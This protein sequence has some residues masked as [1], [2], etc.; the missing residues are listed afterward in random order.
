MCAHNA[1][2]HGPGPHPHCIKDLSVAAGSLDWKELK[3]LMVRAQ[4]WTSLAAFDWGCSQ[5]V[6][7][8]PGTLEG[9]EAG[10]KRVSLR[11]APV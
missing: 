10:T 1:V 2:Y 6:S 7:A 4:G 5:G 3:G 9:V 11:D 8:L